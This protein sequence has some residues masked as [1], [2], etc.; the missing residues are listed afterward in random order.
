MRHGKCK[1]QNGWAACRVRFCFGVGWVGE[2]AIVEEI[3]LV[4][5]WRRLNSVLK[6]FLRGYGFLQSFSTFTHLLKL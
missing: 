4:E 6:I 2:V 1:M 3:A 5:H